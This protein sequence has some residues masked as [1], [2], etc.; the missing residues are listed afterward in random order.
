V[1]G[2]ALAV[3]APL[4]WLIRRRAAPVLAPAFPSLANSQ[5]DRRL[6]AGAALFGL[7]WGLSGYCPG[8]VLVSLASGTSEVLLF[9]LSMFGG[10]WLFGWWERSRAP[11]HQPHAGLTPP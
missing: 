7:G 10:M 5:V 4:S 8:P 3:H 6:L 11:A 1:M 2:G 9:V